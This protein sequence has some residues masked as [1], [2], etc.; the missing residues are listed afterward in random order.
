MQAGLVEGTAQVEASG[1]RILVG[2]ILA[3]LEGQVEELPPLGIDL[4]V[5]ARVQG[6]AVRGPAALEQNHTPPRSP[7]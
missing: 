1:G 4:P 2:Q 6:G 5:E 3:M 7:P